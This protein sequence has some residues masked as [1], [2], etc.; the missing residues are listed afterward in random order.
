MS[1]K[2]MTQGNIVKQ[3]L[4]F[5]FP[6]LLAQLLQQFYSMTDA[7]ILGHFAESR[8]LAAIGSGSLLLSV[9]LNFFTG[10]TTG[11][12]VLIAQYFGGRDYKKL[13]DAIQTALMICMSVGILFTVLGM[14][15]SREVLVF[16]N[17]P[18]SVLAV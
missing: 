18:E 4:V 8:A 11:I 12:G 3:L 1:E 13:K 17:T 16:L 15:F 9:M 2:N 10:F 7:A 5:S 6:V 14:M